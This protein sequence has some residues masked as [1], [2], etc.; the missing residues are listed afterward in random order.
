M[1]CFVKKN[2]NKRVADNLDSLKMFTYAFFIHERRKLSY[3][4]S[5]EILSY[6]KSIAVQQRTE[7]K[8]QPPQYS[9]SNGNNIQ[10]HLSVQ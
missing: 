7:I 10:A 3:L 6:K 8:Q 2:Y 4:N 1:H 5:L 9:S